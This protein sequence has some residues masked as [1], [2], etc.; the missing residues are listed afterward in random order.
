MSQTKPTVISLLL[1]LACFPSF[2][3]D[4]F[5][6][7]QEDHF[8]ANP[9]NW[10]PAYPGTH[11]DADDKVVLMED[12]TI[13]GFSLQVEG[14]LEIGME[15]TLQSRQGEI[16]ISPRGTFNNAGEVYIAGIINGGILNNRHGAQIHIHQ[17]VAQL[18]AI[19][20][21]AASAAFVTLAEL[22]NQG[23]FDNYGLCRIGRDFKNLATF[24]QISSSQLKV[25]GE[26]HL[27]PGSTFYRSQESEVYQGRSEELFLG[28]QLARIYP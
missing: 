2:G 17:F 14:T 12:A 16:I 24:N 13:D 25:A 21:N 3:K 1:L 28:E 5:F 19:T 4:Y 20:H 8:Y 7:A 22:V 23:R 9:A 26:L 11:I 27:K 18:G 10:F 15:A 6:M